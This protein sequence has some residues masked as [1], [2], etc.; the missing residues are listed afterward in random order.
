MNENKEQ[1]QEEQTM[2]TN[3]EPTMLTKEEEQTQ[4]PTKKESKS[5]MDLA[6]L[7]KFL[8]NEKITNAGEP[9]SKLN[10]TTKIKKFMVF[11]ENYKTTNH[12]SEGEYNKLV[13]FFKECLDKKKLQKVKEVNYNKETGE[14]KDIPSLHHNKPMNHFTLK[15]LDKDKDKKNTMT[16]TL[17]TQIVRKRQQGTIKNLKGDGDKEEEE[18]K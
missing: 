18:D 13:T 14:I 17:K 11:A 9:W 6:N 12:L 15:N 10:K 8:E 1:E 5:S 7:D 2:L 4:D 3:E 16:T